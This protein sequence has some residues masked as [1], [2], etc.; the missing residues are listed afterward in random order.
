MNIV[1]KYKN[2]LHFA[3]SFR[4]VF[5]NGYPARKLTVIGVTGTNGK[6]TTSHL[7]YE[8]LRRAGKKTALISTVGAYVEGSFADTGFH[9]TTPDAKLLQPL[10]RKIT[11]KG[12]KYLVLE[13]T[14]HG[15]DQHRTLGCNYWGG[16][17]TNVTHEHLDYHKTFENYR[18]AK[19]K[20]FRGV[21]TAVLNKDDSSFGYFKSLLRKSTKLFTY[22]LKERAFLTAFAIKLKKRSM[23][24]NVKERRKKYHVETTLVGKYNV[25]NILA[26]ACIARSLEI[27]WKEILSA[28]E[29]FQGVKGRMEII[30]C[31]QSFSVI[32]D[33]AHTPNGLENVLK[34][35]RELKP[36]KSKLVAV[37]GC[38]G[39]RDIE[40]RPM[41]GKISS[42]LA[43]ISVFTAEDPRHEDVDKIIDFMVK[44]AKEGRGKF[45]RE[46]DRRKAI[47]FAINN[48]A[49]KGDIIVICGKGPEKSLAIGDKEYPWSDKK[50]AANFLKMPFQ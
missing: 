5:I 14:S 50:I 38:A 27:G 29:D 10:I 24:F 35:L 45:Y 36:R 6:T 9:V 30:D 12:V 37:F 48:L 32:V 7:I 41:M 8:I 43:D 47:D 18:N 19:M 22:S 4:E 26:A 20:L 11:K 16:V 1:G 3:T 21:K 40:K 17:L 49:K 31:G 42:G 28:I 46:P 34:T 15:L 13:T 2:F 44:G 33:F 23:S 39:E 25:S